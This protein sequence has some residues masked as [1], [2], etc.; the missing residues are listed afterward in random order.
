MASGMNMRPTTREEVRA[1]LGS[2]GLLGDVIDNKIR[3]LSGGQ[4]SAR[5]PLPRCCCLSF[6]W[7]VRFFFATPS[8]LCDSVV[9]QACPLCALSLSPPPPLAR[10]PDSVPDWCWPPRCGQSPTFL[11]WMSPRIISTTT[12]WQL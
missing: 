7:G 4:V 2:F 11:L 10:P 6:Q 3:R 9:G 5:P 8:P 1:H 12:R